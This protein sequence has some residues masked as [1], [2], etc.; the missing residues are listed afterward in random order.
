MA[1]E[2]RGWLAREG[3]EMVT[4]W[5]DWLAGEGRE[6]ATEWRDW[7]AGEGR[8]MARVERVVDWGGDGDGHRVM[9]AGAEM[10]GKIVAGASMCMGD[11][12]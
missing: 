6:M 12:M 8:E 11:H 3:R 2:W 9:E 1:T 7:L 4:E 5:R 10:D